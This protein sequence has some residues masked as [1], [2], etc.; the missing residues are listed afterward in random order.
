MDI[1]KCALQAGG[2]GIWKC[3]FLWREEN[4][5]TRRK[6]LGVRTRTNNKFNP[7]M[8]PRPGIEPRP[9]WWKARAL[10]T[11]PSLLLLI[12]C[13]QSH[14]NKKYK[15]MTKRWQHKTSKGSSFGNNTY[16]HAIFFSR[17]SPYF[18]WLFSSRLFSSFSLRFFFFCLI[19][20][21]FR[22]FFL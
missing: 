5:R 22:I 12:R 8:T 6:A 4:R 20:F 16:K 14:L 19:L 18:Y 15:I 1:F 7:P 17:I 21:T 13:F 10:T 2:I 3:W 11:A 9:H